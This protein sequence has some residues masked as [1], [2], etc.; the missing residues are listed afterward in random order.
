VLLD[1]AAQRV[2]AFADFLGVVVVGEEVAA[3]LARGGG[4]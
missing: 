4:A 2:D 3:G 1:A